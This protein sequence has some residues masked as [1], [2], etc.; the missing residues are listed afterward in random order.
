MRFGCLTAF[1]VLILVVAGCGAPAD[2]AMAYELC[3]EVGMTPAGVDNLVL[4]LEI[5]GGPR[6]EPDTVR[7]IS[8][9]GLVN[10]LNVDCTDCV[11]AVV[12]HVWGDQEII[13][14]LGGG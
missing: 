4:L 12:D 7:P 13:Q 11:S 10:C 5:G 3:G 6:P 9:D 1:S 2:L 14:P 8:T